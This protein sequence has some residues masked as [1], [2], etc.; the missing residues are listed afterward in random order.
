VNCADCGH[1]PTVLHGDVPLCGTCFYNRSVT[2]PPQAA[3]DEGGHSD[4]MWRRL[5]DAIASLETIA[6]RIAAE[7]N[8]LVRTREDKSKDR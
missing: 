3:A 2:H 6:S 8:E 1:P 7:M 4:A 5:A